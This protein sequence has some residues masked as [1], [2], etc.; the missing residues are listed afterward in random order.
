MNLSPQHLPITIL[1]LATQS[2]H[3]ES[4][5]SIFH[6]VQ[7]HS[8]SLES[9]I[10]VVTITSSRTS[11]RSTPWV[12]DTLD[13]HLNDARDVISRFLPLVPSSIMAAFLSKS[14][15]YHTSSSIS[16]L[17]FR[18]GHHEYVSSHPVAHGHDRV[19]DNGLARC[20]HH[21]DH[22][23]VLRSHRT[24]Q[25][26][27]V[28]QDSPDFYIYNH[29]HHCHGSLFVHAEHH[30]LRGYRIASRTMHTGRTYHIQ[31]RLFDYQAIQ[32][33]K[34]KIVLNT[35]AANSRNSSVVLAMFCDIR[36]C[37]SQS[38]HVEADFS[39]EEHHLR[40]YILARAL[41]G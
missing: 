33:Y 17:L 26:G 19:H 28:H 41:W 29:T 25:I 30:I 12:S 20:D 18:A 38:V 7:N 37:V 11:L 24:R 14:S 16:F 9:T 6:V 15:I 39:C 36:N 2:E 21:A 10:S 32:T 8:S 23:R 34:T 3:L 27:H 13:V 31:V 40:H 5:L 4:H 1:F 22:L 35:S